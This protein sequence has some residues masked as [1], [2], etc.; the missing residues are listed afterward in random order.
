[1]RTDIEMLLDESAIRQVL[2]RITQAQ[3]N[4]DEESVV[5]EFT[6]D[7]SWTSTIPGVDLPPIQGREAL[8]AHFHG[9][10]E[11]QRNMGVQG[12]H[13]VSNILYGQRTPDTQQVHSIVT[14][15]RV[16]E[17]KTDVGW[18]AMY[19]DTFVK[20]ASGWKIR[21]RVFHADAMLPVFSAK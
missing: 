5:Q 3:D 19:D 9:Q 8:L 15:V 20:T 14:T 21:S 2:Y 13:L 16:I 18:T 1:M 4:F 6:D 12:R 7:V 10:H 17:G 11:K